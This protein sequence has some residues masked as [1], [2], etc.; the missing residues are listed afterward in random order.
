MLPILQRHTEEGS[1]IISDMFS[2]YVNPR[3]GESYLNSLGYDHHYVNHSEN[4]VDPVNN[5][6]HTNNIEGNWR[7]LKHSISHIKKPVKDDH[8]D[9]Y[10]SS[11]M[12]KN[13]SK[14]EDFFNIFL[15]ILGK[16]TEIYF[17]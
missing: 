2:V 1:T 16:L 17:S 13:G 12:M 6:I 7:R 15:D 10:L 3:S 8:V 5:W 11:F 9:G 14:K 4:Y